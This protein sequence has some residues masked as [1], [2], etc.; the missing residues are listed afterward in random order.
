MAFKT[1][2]AATRDKQPLVLNWITVAFF[3]IFHVLALLAPWYFTWSALGVTLF[4]HWFLGRAC[5]RSHNQRR[6]A[7]IMS[8]AR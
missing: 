3:A 1:M 6:I 7:P 2:Q 8:I 5:L 4:L